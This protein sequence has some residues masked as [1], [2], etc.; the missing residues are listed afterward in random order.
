MPLNRRQYPRPFLAASSG[1]TL[2]LLMLVVGCGTK[3][4]ASPQ[5]AQPEPAQ[6]RPSMAIADRVS[7]GVKVKLGLPRGSS[8]QFVEVARKWGVDFERY[9]DIRGQHRLIEANGG[10]V[11]MLD[12][13]QDGSLDL[14]FT[15]GCRLPRI[16]G[17]STRLSPLFRNIDAR[18]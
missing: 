2:S 9:D 5:R 12:Y 11:A 15:N 1:A 16:E 13:D 10:G 8:P 18:L 4:P 3:Q 6:P 14:F 17:D 7:Q